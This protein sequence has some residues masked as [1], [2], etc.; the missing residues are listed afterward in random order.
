MEDASGCEIGELAQ[1]AKNRLAGDIGP[2]VHEWLV[3]DEVFQG[4]RA[5]PFT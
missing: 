3:I 5:M 1:Q 4:L 2:A